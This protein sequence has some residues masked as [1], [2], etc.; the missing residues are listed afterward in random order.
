MEK[1]IHWQLCNKLKFDRT[2]KL[3][4]HYPARQMR[5]TNSAGILR[6]KLLRHY[7]QSEYWEESWWLAEICCHSSSSERPSANAD[8]KNS[9]GVTAIIILNIIWT[10]L[11][12]L[13]NN[14]GHEGNGDTN[15]NW[16]TRHSY[17]GTVIVTGETT[18][19]RALLSSARILR[20][21]LEAWADLLLLRLQLETI[22]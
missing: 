9:Q 17:Q 7:D 3:Y 11:G 22:G 20:R 21:V 19:T 2:N 6:Y 18:Q 14:V 8:V 10:L 4:M 13:K 1:K 12:N 15:C 16:C 5:R